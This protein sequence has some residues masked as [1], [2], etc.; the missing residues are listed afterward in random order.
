MNMKILKV[1]LQCLATH[2]AYITVND[3]CSLEKAIETAKKK[4]DNFPAEN[5]RYVEDSDE[6]CEDECEFVE[7]EDDDLNIQLYRDK[8][9]REVWTEHVIDDIYSY[10]EDNHMTLNDDLVVKAARL[11]AMDGKY[12]CNLPYW[13]NIANV[14]KCVQ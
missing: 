2:T 12:D 13:E 1:E 9:Y 10:L 7:K 8:I 4:L 3:D 6:I 5:L 14:I 11:Y